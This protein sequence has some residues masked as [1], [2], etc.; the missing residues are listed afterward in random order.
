MD[1]KNLVKV[2]VE[3]YED[4]TTGMVWLRMSRSAFVKMGVGYR[5]SGVVEV[6][7]VKS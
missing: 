1:R 7:P 4:R 2:G 3:L 6:P 5:R